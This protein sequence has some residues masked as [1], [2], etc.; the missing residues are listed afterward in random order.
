MVVGAGIIMFNQAPYK[1]TMKFCARCDML[2]WETKRGNQD[3][4]DIAE[5]PGYHN[6][7]KQYEEDKEMRKKYP[8]LQK[9]WDSYQ[10][11]KRL[12]KP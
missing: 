2:Y 12:L 8:S 3:L 10:V 5:F 1:A 7:F 11:H 9:Q 4:A 6:L